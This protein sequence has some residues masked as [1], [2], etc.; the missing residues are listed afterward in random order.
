MAMAKPVVA[1]AAAAEGIDAVDGE[2][3]LIAANVA[4]EAAKVSA[5]LADTEERLR[6]GQAARAHVM[7]HYGWD[8]QLAPLDAIL[9]GGAAQ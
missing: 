9:H 8:A 7:A 4:D 2:H 1:S 3:L 6:I 5:L